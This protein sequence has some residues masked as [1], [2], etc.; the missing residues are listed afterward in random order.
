MISQVFVKDT[1]SDQ[2]LGLPLDVTLSPQSEQVRKTL[3][4]L[5]HA[6]AHQTGLVNFIRVTGVVIY[7][8]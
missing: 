3:L 6:V 7:H 4:P 8:S 5:R 1:V 2:S